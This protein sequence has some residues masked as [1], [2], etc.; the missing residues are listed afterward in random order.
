LVIW[1][2]KIIIDMGL[3]QRR[4]S[5]R[6]IGGSILIV[7]G[8]D[9]YSVKRF[10]NSFGSKIGSKKDTFREINVTPTPTPTPV[11]PQVILD[12]LLVDATTYFIAGLD[13]YIM[14]VE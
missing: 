10:P 14:Y 3:G 13:E 8:Q 4:T 5:G 11:P 12:A 6:S 1:W 7:P 2:K 9:I